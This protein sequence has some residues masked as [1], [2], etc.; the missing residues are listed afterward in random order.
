MF[1]NY[2]LGKATALNTPHHP[3]GAKASA[4][5][6]LRFPR[7]RPTNLTYVYV[8]AATSIVFSVLGYILGRK[9]DRFRRLSAIDP[10]TGL[11][12]RRALESR[13]PDEW[14]RSKRYGSRLSMLLIDIRSEHGA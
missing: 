9:V 1:K 6:T 4:N 8:F 14:R 7:K 10:L 13:L 5:G 3:S 11:P 2:R 12:N